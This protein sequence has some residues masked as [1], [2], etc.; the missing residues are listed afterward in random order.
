MTEYVR[1]AAGVRF[2][3]EPIGAPIGSKA[4][5]RGGKGSREPVQTPSQFRHPETGA[6]MG[7]SEIGD[8]YEELFRQKG[9]ALLERHFGTGAYAPIAHAKVGGALSSRTT[10]LDFKLNGT[11]GGEL[12]TL[13]VKAKNQKTAIKAEELKRKLTATQ[14]AGLKPV[15]AVQVVDPD[16]GHVEVYAHP[17]FASK[18]VTAMEH[19][20]SYDYSMGDF[21]NAQQATGHWDKRYA[22]A[23]ASGGSAS[24]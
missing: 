17:A 8:T 22:R 19:V 3:K 6:P 21:K 4:G 2:F 10:P 1:T 18:K 11:H 13:N 7:K 24:G 15:L 5:T 12:K 20:G 14:Q 9:A 23:A 16:T